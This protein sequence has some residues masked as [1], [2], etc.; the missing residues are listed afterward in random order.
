MMSP[1]NSSPIL[2]YIGRQQDGC[3]Y[4]L[5]PSSLRRVRAEHPSAKPASQVFIRFD[6]DGSFE[7][8]HG[9]LWAQIA[10]MLTGLNAKQ[11]EAMGG[12]E[13]YEPRTEIRRPVTARAS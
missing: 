8:L 9:P 12:V 5:H 7:D 4:Q 3:V 10:G 6:S 13:L 2:I 1:T 11:L